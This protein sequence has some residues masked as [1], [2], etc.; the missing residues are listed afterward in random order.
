MKEFT[1]DYTTNLTKKINDTRSQLYKILKW[2]EAPKL[3]E[4]DVR[5]VLEVYEEEKIKEQN[6]IKDPFQDFYDAVVN[7]CYVLAESIGLL[8]FI[9]WLKN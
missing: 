1:I 8:K 3:S 2:G 9:N 6:M 4:G 7:F 5:I